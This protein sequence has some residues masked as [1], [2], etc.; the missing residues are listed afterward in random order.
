MIF[1]EIA[2]YMACKKMHQKDLAKVVGVSQM[3]ISQKLNG[4]SEFVLSEM[5]KIKEHFK[6]IAPDITMEKLF[7]I[8]LA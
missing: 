5:Q 4:N 1:P 8:F 7:E 3:A 6:D 2:K